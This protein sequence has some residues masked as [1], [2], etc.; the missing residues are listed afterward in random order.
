MKNFGKIVIAS[1]LMI[2]FYSN[3]FAYGDTPPRKPT[4]VNVIAFITD[5]QSL[6]EA[7]EQIQIDAIFK[8]EWNDPHLAFDSKYNEVFTS[9]TKVIFNMMRYLKDVDHKYQLSM[10]WFTP[11]K[12]TSNKNLSKW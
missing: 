1:V 12:V 4:L 8:F 5:I 9:Y 11:N 6:D 10:K 3:I 7:N 2:I